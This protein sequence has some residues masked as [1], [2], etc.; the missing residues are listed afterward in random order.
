MGHVMSPKWKTLNSY[1]ILFNIL[2]S[3]STKLKQLYLEIIK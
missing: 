3:F 1:N 2:N